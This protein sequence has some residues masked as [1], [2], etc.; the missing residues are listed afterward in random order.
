MVY[1]TY[2]ELVTPYKPTNITGAGATLYQSSLSQDA[3]FAK[4]PRFVVELA[5]F[6]GTESLMIQLS[7]ENDIQGGAP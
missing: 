4:P 2:N 3:R 7:L 6:G 5:G 1:G